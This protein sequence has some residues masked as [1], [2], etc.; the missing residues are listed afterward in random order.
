MSSSS[1]KITKNCWVVEDEIKNLQLMKPAEPTWN[2]L[3]VFPVQ[4]VILSITLSGRLVILTLSFTNE[5]E[6]EIVCWF[7]LPSPCLGGIIQISIFTF[8]VLFPLSLPWLSCFR[9]NFTLSKKMLK[10]FAPP[11]PSSFGVLPACTVSLSDPLPAVF[12]SL[13]HKESMWKRRQNSDWCDLEGPLW[14]IRLP[15]ATSTTRMGKSRK[16]WLASGESLFR[17]LTF[18][19]KV[20][21]VI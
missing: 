20:T 5:A 12:I 4:T 2:R 19:E 11:P 8:L 21:K 6:G 10:P 7:Y 13:S 16:S 17:L 14:W 3:Y 18:V 15:A 9:N 1:L